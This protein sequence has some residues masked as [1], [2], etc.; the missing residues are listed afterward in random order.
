MS[1]TTIVLAAALAFAGACTPQQ[2]R[3]AHASTA[4]VAPAALTTT[5]RVALDGQNVVTLKDG[6]SRI[7][8]RGAGEFDLVASAPLARHPGANEPLLAVLT[9]TSERVVKQVAFVVTDRRAT[10][11]MKVPDTGTYRLEIWSGTQFLAGNTFIAVALPTLDGMRA[12]ELHQDAAPKLELSSA[13]AV[14]WSHW[15]S[16]ETDE[17]YIAEWWH[18]NK[19]TSVA[20]SERSTFQRDVLA[21]ISVATSPDAFA[22]RPV[23]RFVTSR[24]PVPDN[25]ARQIGAWELRIYRDNH[26]TLALGFTVYANGV[27]RSAAAGR[28]HAKNR[29]ELD[30]TR[31]SGAPDRSRELAKIPHEKPTQTAA[32]PVTVAEIRALTRSEILRSQRAQVNQSF[33][34]GLVPQMRQ[35]IT[36]VGK[37]WTDSERPN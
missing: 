35:L 8:R 3:G 17:A 32:M 9:D 5:L 10:V 34:A 11:R 6:S 30:V 7:P 20:G 2:Q 31:P 4:T 13:S 26:P 18:D 12:L 19:R 37:P 14:A 21:E 16:A 33:D 1:K 36:Q 25:V 24:F 15:D 29:I 23:W 22:D 28:V 27:V